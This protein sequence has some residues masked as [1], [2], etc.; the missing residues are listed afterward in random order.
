VFLQV[1]GGAIAIIATSIALG[2]AICLASGAVTRVWAAPM[3]GFAALLVIANAA[4]Q[5]PGKAVTA[6]VLVLLALVFAVAFLIWRRSMAIVPADVGVVVLALAAVSI[7]FL[8]SGRVGLL[9]VS[10]DNDTAAHLMWA[11]GLR[12]ARMASLASATAGYPLGPHSLVAAL[13]TLFGMPLDAGFAALLMSVPALTALSA[14]GLLPKQA[15]WRRM[16]AGLMCALVYLL[17]SYYGEGAFKETI[18]AGFLLAFVVEVGQL[19]AGWLGFDSRRQWARLAPAIVLVA[20]AIYTYSYVALAWFVLTLGLWGVAA[21]VAS[22]GRAVRWVTRRNLALAARPAAIVAA[23]LVILILPVIGQILSLFQSLGGAPSSLPVP[24]GNLPGPLSAFEMFG[25]S[26]N[27]DFRYVTNTFHAGEAAALAFVAVGY[28]VIWSLRRRSL[29]LPAAAGAA[30]LIWHFSHPTQQPYVAA[31]AMVIASPLLVALA[32]QALLTRTPG[33]GLSRLVRLAAALAFC[34]LL[35]YSTLHSLRDA[36]VQAP[37]PSQNLESFHRFIGPRRVMFLG[38]DD[39]AGW[40]LRDAQ[41]AGPP[42]NQRLDKPFGGFGQA[43]DFDSIDP[44][45]L[46]AFPFVVTTNS[47]YNSQPYENFRLVA[48]TRFYELWKPVG[49]TVSRRVIEPPGSPGAVLNCRTAAGRR[50]RA[51]HGVASIF[52]TAPLTF[53]G[54]SLPAGDQATVRL[55]LPAGRWEISAQYFSSFKVDFVAP[56]LEV[57]MPAY[58]GR[59]GPFFGVGPVTGRGPKSPVI[60]IISTQHPSIF[61]SSFDNLYMSIPVIVATRVPDTRRLVPLSQACGK[62]VDWYRTS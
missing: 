24:L 40:L 3:V 22:P 53:P 7:P 54:P 19:Q 33:D 13:G 42:G 28:G 55:A 31:K 41:V 62:Y 52:P 27:P 59:Q 56:G 23:G 43:A 12:S 38:N 9:G 1:Y 21:A 39:Y 45:A 26:F 32:L 36:P 2:R 60:L 30:V 15:A 57:T 16:L 17:A 10:L 6:N 35:G 5:L 49:P 8:A 46:H 18:M 44:G 25:V 4:I 51:Q 29:L 48:T 58:L 11:E 20:G 34:F 61:T 14:M 47:P 37:V 50:L